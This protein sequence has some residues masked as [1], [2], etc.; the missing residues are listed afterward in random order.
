MWNKINQNSLLSL[1]EEHVII[2][3]P[4]VSPIPLFSH[5]LEADKDSDYSQKFWPLYM[6]RALGI[7]C[8]EYRH[9]LRAAQLILG[10]IWHW[11]TTAAHYYCAPFHPT[12][13]VEGPR[14]PDRVRSYE[15]NGQKG[16]FKAFMTTKRRRIIL[17]K[18]FF[19]QDTIWKYDSRGFRTGVI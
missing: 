14:I 3:A 15:V 4:A 13:N 10:G 9:S 17:S 6:L 16:P 8:L 11:L 7:G 12:A 2:K 19:S 1:N 18:Q 5:V